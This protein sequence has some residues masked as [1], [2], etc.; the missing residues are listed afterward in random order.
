[1]TSPETDTQRPFVRYSW[2]LLA[3]VTAVILWGAYVR[4]SGSGAGCGSHWPLCNGE[5]VPRHP[6]AKTLIELGHR[7][8][9]GLSAVGVLIQLLW[10]RRLFARGSS[11]RR[12]AAYGAALMILEVMIGA[13]I[14]L[15]EYVDMNASVGRAIW[16]VVHLVNTFMLVGALTLTAHVAGGGKP[17]R[18]RLDD[19]RALMGL[20]ALAGTLFVGASGAVA[21]LGDTLFPAQHLRTAL[22][23][24]LS[25]TAH[26][27]VRLRLVHP[28][29]AVFVGGFLLV[30]RMLLA[31]S[32]ASRDAQRW[33]MCLRVSVLA[34]LALG[35][36][37]VMLLAPIWMQ[38]VH[39]FMADVV[40]ISLVMMLAY[41]LGEEDVV[42]EADGATHED[43]L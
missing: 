14:V 39:L 12:W 16:M 29:A 21:A 7:I 18:F 38:L 37:N 43:E 6:S 36:V 31:G 2:L 40:W 10:S 11:T 33:G 27:L 17:P 26:L 19:W 32:S 1:M 35:L 30:V 22:A 25:A 3:Y 9:S 41:R 8:T 23:A 15:L 28:F 42:V 34:Q 13:G 4:A 5:I 24:D 20:A